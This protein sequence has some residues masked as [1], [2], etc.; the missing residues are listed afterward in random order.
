MSVPHP[1]SVSYRTSTLFKTSW[2]AENQTETRYIHKVYV[3]STTKHSYKLF[4][5]FLY[6]ET[7]SE[8]NTSTRGAN[9]Y[10]FLNISGENKPKQ[11]WVLFRKFNSLQCWFFLLY[12]YKDPTLPLWRNLDDV[13]T[14][15]CNSWLSTRQLK[16]V[17]PLH[18]SVLFIKQS[19][20]MS[21]A[22]SFMY[23]QYMLSCPQ[24]LCPKTLHQAPVCLQPAKL[25]RASATEY[26]KEGSLPTWYVLPAFFLQQ[27]LKHLPWS[28][29]KWVS[30]CIKDSF[31]VPTMTVNSV[32]FC[33]PG[34]LCDLKVEWH[35]MY[36]Q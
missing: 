4:G 6:E 9:L 33:L 23:K 36:E 18:R 25:L 10:L 32:R 20:S 17:L 1:G 11:L 3:F 21:R 13:K 15:L 8:D 16:Y 30:S 19:H 26:C 34:Q 27:S 35:V 2:L 29:I 5:F 14:K 24:S 28:D 12:K 7:F 22:H 31:F